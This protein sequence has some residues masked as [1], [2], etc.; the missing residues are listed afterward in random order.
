MSFSKQLPVI[1]LIVAFAAGLFFWLRT[2]SKKLVNMAEYSLVSLKIH[3]FNLLD[4][5]LKASILI[6]NPSDLAIKINQYRVEIYRLSASGKKLLAQTP[7]SSLTIP[8]QSSIINDVQFTV[9]NTQIIDLIVGSLKE[10]MESQLKGKI[11][12]VIKADL[13]GQYI[14]KEIKY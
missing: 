3:K 1:A 2:N 5:V 8:A 12:I 4:T 13:L 9:S 10:G 7:V 11:S 6:K 14:E